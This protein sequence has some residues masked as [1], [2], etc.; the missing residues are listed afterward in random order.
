M[1]MQKGK[2]YTETGWDVHAPALKDTLLWFKNRYGDTN[3]A[4]L[5]R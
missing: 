5:D 2:I 4:I 3:G 1:V